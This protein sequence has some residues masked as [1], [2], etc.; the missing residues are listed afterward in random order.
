MVVTKKQATLGSN[1]M[2][3][4]LKVII[5]SFLLPLRVFSFL[6]RKFFSNMAVT[7][8]KPILFY[9]LYLENNKNQGIPFK[10]RKLPCLQGNPK[11]KY[12]FL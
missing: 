12:S 7:L 1:R 4:V 10:P 6:I 3:I 5:Q 11:K 8:K 2:N 9:L